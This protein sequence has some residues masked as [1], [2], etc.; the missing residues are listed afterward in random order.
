MNV[1]TAPIIDGS[2]TFN[3]FPHNPAL[4]LAVIAAEIVPL[5]K[6]SPAPFTAAN[7]IFSNCS[8]SISPVFIN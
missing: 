3:V 1:V 6:P 8:L 7:P 5:I 2:I 4:Q